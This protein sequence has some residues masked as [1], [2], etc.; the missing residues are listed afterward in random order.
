[1]DLTDEEIATRINIADRRMVR[2]WSEKFRCSED[3]LIDAVLVVG[4]QVRVV[5]DYLILN[6]KCY[7][8]N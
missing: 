8:G 5:R 7:S 1:M 4:N 3:D 2:E 6:R